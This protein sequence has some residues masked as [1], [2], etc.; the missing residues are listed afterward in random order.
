LMCSIVTVIS[1]ATNVDTGNWPILLCNVYTEHLLSFRAS[2][3]VEQ[4]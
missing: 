2:A 4:C 1:K 3:N